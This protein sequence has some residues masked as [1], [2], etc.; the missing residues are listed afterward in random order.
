MYITDDVL[1]QYWKLIE[2]AKANLY[3]QIK[4]FI[5]INV[6]LQKMSGTQKIALALKKRFIKQYL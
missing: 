6:L 3:K 1:Q 4:N 2:N 5:I